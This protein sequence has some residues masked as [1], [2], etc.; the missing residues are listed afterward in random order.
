M[1]KSKRKLFI[2]RAMAIVMLLS[3]FVPLGAAYGDTAEPVPMSNLIFTEQEVSQG[4]APLGE[5]AELNTDLPIKLSFEFR[6]P[7]AGDYG[8]GGNDNLPWSDDPDA[9]EL[10]GKHKFQ[11]R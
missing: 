6:V 11:S 10:L 5:N 4:G 7:V 2:S 1:V 3:V 9:T 8:E